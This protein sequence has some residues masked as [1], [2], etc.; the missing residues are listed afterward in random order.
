LDNKI[1]KEIIRNGIPEQLPCLRALLWKTMIGYLPINDLSQWKKITLE[2][3][4][5]YNSVKKEFQDFENNIKDE[6]DRR[7]INQINLDLPRTRSEIPFSGKNQ[8]YQKMKLIMMYYEESY[9]FMLK[10][11]LMFLMSKE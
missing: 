8:K 1:L 7:I 11:I 4:K 6:G 10:S 5:N 2:S 9:I 3:Y